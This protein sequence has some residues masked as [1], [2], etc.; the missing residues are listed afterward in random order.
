MKSKLNVCPSLTQFGRN[1]KS[2][3]VWIYTS[4]TESGSRLLMKTLKNVFGYRILEKPIAID[5]GLFVIMVLNPA[6]NEI[7]NAL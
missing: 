1:D 3:P 6:F 4:M 5:N 7:G 2:K